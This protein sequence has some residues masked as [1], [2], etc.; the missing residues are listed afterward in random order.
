VVGDDLP[1]LIEGIGLL[2]AVQLQLLAV[3]VV[4]QAKK[5][6]WS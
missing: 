1:A 2:A 5:E 6:L 4:R 3:E